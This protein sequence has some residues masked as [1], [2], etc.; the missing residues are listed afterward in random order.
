MFALWM[1]W[2]NILFESFTLYV[3]NLFQERNVF[4]FGFI[5]L[6]FP[7]QMLSNIKHSLRRKMIMTSSW[8]THQ[9]L[10]KYSI[11]Y[12]KL[13]TYTTP[14]SCPLKLPPQTSNLNCHLFKLIIPRILPNIYLLSY[15]WSKN[16]LRFCLKKIQLPSVHCNSYKQCEYARRQRNTCDRWVQFGVNQKPCAT[17]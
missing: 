14:S 16:T 17:S 8:T 12:F 4:S 2:L 7:R 3:E 13:P 9:S 15:S 6:T 10:R 5:T 11:E 1:F